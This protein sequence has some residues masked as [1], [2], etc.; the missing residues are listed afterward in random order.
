MTILDAY[1]VLALMRDEVAADEVRAI[2][3]DP[4]PI[5]ISAVNLAETIDRLVRCEEV[6]IPIA[7]QAIELLKAAGLDIVPLDSSMA[8]RSGQL[9]ANH[10]HRTRSSLSLADC[11]C[12]ATAEELQRPLATADPA[13]ARMA[14]A[15]GIEVVALPDRRGHRP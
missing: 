3:E 14:R 9:R 8:R 15:E 5:S 13:L 7:D 12:A 11:A 4:S 6:A 2:M 1:A 10:Y